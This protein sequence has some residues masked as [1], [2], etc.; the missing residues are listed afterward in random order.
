MEANDTFAT[1]GTASMLSG[2]R[3][4]ARPSSFFCWYMFAR[5]LDF[6]IYDQEAT[7][8]IR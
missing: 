6:P 8:E 1:F 2:R 7:E 3:S 5:M 4:G